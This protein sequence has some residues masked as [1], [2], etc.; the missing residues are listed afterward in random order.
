MDEIQDIEGL[1]RRALQAISRIDTLRDLTKLKNDNLGSTSWLA[2]YSASIKILSQEKKPII[3]KAVSEARRKILEACQDRDLA[4]RLNAQNEQF[5]R[6]TLDITALPTRIFPGARHPIHVLQD[7]ILDF[8]LMRGWSV[9]EGPELESE[10]LNFDAL[11][12]GPFHPAREESDT[13]FAEP[14][15]A[16]MLLRTHTSPVQL[17][18]LVSN[19]LPLYCVSSGKVFR[20]DPLDATHTPVF[21]QL[22]GL[23]CDRNITLGH[24]K[25]TV[26]DLAGY[27]FGAEVNL[28]MRCNY[29]PFTEPS[30]EFD[31]SR[32]GIDW[33]EWGGCGLVNS[34]VL[35]MA[36]ID[37]V[38][39]T[40]FAFGFGLERT[41]QFIHSLSDMRDIVEGDIRFSQ[42][43]GLK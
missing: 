34:K 23:V 15:S 33:T 2:K 18:A 30:A 13:I 40:G 3:G 26:E 42:Q 11:N 17:R 22:E 28:R 41:L 5:T 7:K 9:V 20:S 14:R 19:P 6:E 4:L 1:T 38:H 36:G 37:T 25:G 35:S 12:I 24:L 31:I 29:F 8:F 10:W 43:F 21:H 27:L 16:S 32:D 39:Y